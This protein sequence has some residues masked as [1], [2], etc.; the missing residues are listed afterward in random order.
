MSDA[1]RD[2]NF[3]PVALGQSSTSATTTLPFLI[4][5]VTGRLL[6]DSASGSGDVVGPASA[7][8]NAVA[9]FSGVTGKLLKNSTIQS[10]TTVFSPTVS[11]G[12]S[13]GS[14]TL[15]WS[16]L[17]LA[18]GAVVNFNNGD[19][20]ITHSTNTLTFTGASSG[21][22][23]DAMNAPTANDGAA[24]GSVTLSWSDLFLAS[25]A[26]INIAN[27][28]WVATHSAGILT[29]STGDLRVT[30][31]GAN[32]ASVVTVGGAQ[33][34]TSKILTSATIT[35][36]LTPTANDGA[37]LGTGALSFADLFLASGAVINF[38][39]G[40]YTI[41][42][43]AGLLTT[44]GALTLAGTLALAA[45]SITMTGSIAATGARV[46]KVWATDI[47]STNMPTVGG[48]AIL[49]SL[50]AP[51]F[52]TIEMGTGQT[53]TTLSRAAAGDLAVEGVSVLTTS[54]TKT[55][56]NKRRTRRL[57]TTNAPGATPTTNTD[58]VDIM[59][60][61]GLGTAITSMTTNLSGSPVDGD[62]VEF[63]FIDDGTAR[64]ITWG[65]SF[66]ATTVALP[67]TTVISTRLRVGFEWDGSVW[68]CVAV[69]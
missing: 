28:D 26:L 69:A 3:V 21:Y 54:N 19:V 14:G 2:Q 49:T 46:T 12:N 67:T 52:N 30:T 47:E 29:V 32:S 7:T 15:M 61:T 22:L 60:F 36:G 18:A 62:L 58:N 16:D 39:N 27:G 5:S 44:N 41:T 11:D 53:D 63:R 25:G 59:N 1:N 6:T 55:M 34:L 66:A 45:N 57:T 8:D 48:T 65:A 38:N 31:A 68:R 64:G 23:Y 35:T 20:L 50:T 37:A 33:T 43:S 10:V 56:T 4:S 24:L 51:T 42:H 9:L 40:N 13:L 17:F